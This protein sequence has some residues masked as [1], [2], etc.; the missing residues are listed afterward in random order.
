MSD[1]E[2]REFIRYMKEITGGLATCINIHGASPDP[3][4]DAAIGL[5][6]LKFM[7]ESLS[8][9][10][11]IGLLLKD[12]YKRK[13]EKEKEEQR[14]R[15]EEERRSQEQAEAQR[16][17]KEAEEKWRTAR[18]VV[19]PPI[20][21]AKRHLNHGEYDA[22][23]QAAREAIEVYLEKGEEYL[24]DM[25]TLDYRLCLNKIKDREEKERRQI[26]A[27]I[28]AKEYNKRLNEGITR[29]KRLLSPNKKEHQ[30]YFQREIK[31]CR[32][33]SE[34][35]TQFL[36]S[37]E[38]KAFD[39]ALV[40]VASRKLDNVVSNDL[41][42][43]IDREYF[44]SYFLLPS[45]EY[46]F[47]G[48]P[49][50]DFMFEVFAVVEVR[51]WLKPGQKKFGDYVFDLPW[52]EEK[53]YSV[54]L[55][56]PEFLGYHYLMLT[57]ED[58]GGYVAWQSIPLVLLKRLLNGDTKP[59][60]FTITAAADGMITYK[61]PKFS[62]EVNIPDDFADYLKR[63]GSIDEM[64]SMGIMTRKIAD[65]AESASGELEVERKVSLSE[66]R[67]RNSKKAKAFQLFSQGKGPSSPEVK[68]LDLHKSTRFKYYNQYLAVHKL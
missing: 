28:A 17:E 39:N 32:Y 8:P 63:I 16:K 20:G 42:Q 15:Q 34:N 61:I 5:T 52:R 2:K 43:F 59:G 1:D 14:R 41:H 44:R 23:I 3:M 60:G 64:V 29:L 31:D 26:A 13:V 46:N 68:A 22:F 49:C 4:S 51:V 36:S 57:P 35:F 62:E 11:R 7:V 6:V 67:G 50:L 56:Q 25:R 54:P 27:N 58:L 53:G 38:E 48:V 12:V 21:D 37:E 9:M 47:E 18:K 10:H 66:G 65:I 30:G 40:S 45:A 24:D 19:N 33:T 55:Q